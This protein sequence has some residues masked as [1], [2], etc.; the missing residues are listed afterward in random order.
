MKKIVSV[1]N[2]G[3]VPPPDVVGK[4]DV[5]FVYWFDLIVLFMNDFRWKYVLNGG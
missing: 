3:V 1:L 4:Y 2:E 5:K